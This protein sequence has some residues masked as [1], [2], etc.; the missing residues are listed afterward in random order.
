MKK[1]ISAA[2]VLSCLYTQ[3]QEK[4]IRLGV[5][6]GA[7][8]SLFTNTIPP[9][10]DAAGTKYEYFKRDIRSSAIGGITAEFLLTKG[11]SIGAE[12][13]YSSRGMMYSEKNDYVVRVDE[14][15]SRHA[16]NRFV[17]VT[18]YL[19]VPVTINYNFNPPTSRA[20]IAA[21]AGLAPAMSIY[22][23]TKLIYADN[24]DGDGYRANNEHASLRDVRLYNNNILFGIQAGDRKSHLYADFRSAYTLRPVFSRSSVNRSNL[25]TKML[26]FS[27]AVGVKI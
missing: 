16:R 6:M 19:E 18:D 25:D 21:Y 8:F 13:L 7:N 26:S 10:D 1:L 23:K 15:G 22:S 27:L 3:A 24:T 14:N 17:Y 2:L 4:Q 20:W 12:V 9:F 11:F 5:K